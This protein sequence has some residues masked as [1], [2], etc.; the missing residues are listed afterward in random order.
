MRLQIN[1]TWQEKI[2]E[3]FREATANESTPNISELVSF[4]KASQ[5]LIITIIEKGYIP[6]IENLGAGV[7]RISIKGSCC[8]TCGRVL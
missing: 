3:I 4:N 5:W 2:I 6:K 7:K 8:P 1:P